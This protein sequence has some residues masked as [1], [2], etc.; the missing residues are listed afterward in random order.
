LER[1]EKRGITFE[2]VNSAIDNGEIIELYID[3]YPYPSAL[4]LGYKVNNTPVHLVIGV[5]DGLAWLITA[6]NPDTGK[7]ENDFKTRKVEK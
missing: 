4:I 2:D 1:I 6:Y 7:W 3:D 5:G